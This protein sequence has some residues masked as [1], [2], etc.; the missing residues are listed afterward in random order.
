MIKTVAHHWIW[1]AFLVGMI[2]F[3]AAPKAHA[4]IDSQE[5]D[6]CVNI[7]GDP[8]ERGV[9]NATAGLVI[10]T[11]NSDVAS[12]VASDALNTLCPKWIPLVRQTQQD[13]KNSQ[14][15]TTVT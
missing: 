4:D 2:V 12:A 10:E 9:W 14:S 5:I 15:G 1:M 13:L 11:G 8:T 6:F 7:A 3:L